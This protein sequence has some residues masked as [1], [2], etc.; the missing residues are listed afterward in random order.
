MQKIIILEK[1]KNSHK[2]RK[3]YFIVMQCSSIQT[4]KTVQIAK[5]SQKMKNR[6]PSFLYWITK[7]YENYLLFKKNVYNEYTLVLK[8]IAYM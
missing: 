5:E 1:Y 6:F 2:N 3:P 8:M 4:K 7:I